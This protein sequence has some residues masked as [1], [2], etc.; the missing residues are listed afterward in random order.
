MPKKTVFMKIFR[1]AYPSL[2]MGGGE[3]RSYNML[4]FLSKKAEITLVPPAFTTCGKSEETIEETVRWASKLNIYVPE[5]VISF[6]KECKHYPANPLAEVKLEINYYSKFLGEVKNSDVIFSDYTLYSIVKA[7]S[8]LKRKTATKSILF[9]QIS[10][11]KLLRSLIWNIK[12]KGL[13][14]STLKI[15]LSSLYTS[16][17][18][19]KFMEYSKDIDFLLG[20][21]KASVDDL[22]NAKMTRKDIPW[23]V[24]KPA[25]AF[26]RELLNYST[27]NKEDYAVFFARLLPE[28][29][30]FDL[31]AIWKKV[32]EKMPKAKLIIVGK[33]D[34]EKTEKKFLSMAK[35]TGIEYIGFRSRGDTDLLRKVAKAKVFVYP[36]YVDSFAL[37]ILESLAL[38]TPVVTYDIPAIR[39]IYGGLKAVNIVNKFDVNG[40]ARKVIEIYS[41]DPEEMF[42]DTYRKFIEF[43]SSWER[44]AGAEYQAL[45]EFTGKD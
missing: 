4:K 18:F 3:V 44:V 13:S 22:I 30:L 7:M 45:R 20:V 32:R 31:P 40:M 21:S 14:L 42:D 28:K 19:H 2:T 37:V 10:Y 11:S 9:S 27:L 12:T 35:D 39:E 15:Y 43:Y 26:E 29:G 8:I 41:R 38:K 16:G 24:L 33:F 23:K 5:E 25:N 1:I 36:T 17:L 34:N 6:A